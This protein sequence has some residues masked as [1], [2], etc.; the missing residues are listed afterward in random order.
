[1]N[2]PIPHR[3]S[4]P[5]GVLTVPARL[6]AT[7]APRGP[8]GWRLDGWV[9][10]FLFCFVSNAQIPG[11]QISP[12][13]WMVAASIGL[14][15]ASGKPVWFSLRAPENR[16][17][18]WYALALLGDWLLS[19]LYGTRQQMSGIVQLSMLIAATYAIQN[20]RTQWGLDRLVWFF[21][22][23]LGASMVVFLLGL[24]SED[25]MQRLAV[26]LPDSRSGVFVVARGLSRAPHIIGY[27]ITALWLFL[28]I[29]VL[30]GRNLVLRGAYGIGSAFCTM[31]L[32][33][34]GT[35]SGA[36][37]I[38]VALAI[39]CVMIPRMRRLTI[40][41]AV[42]L[43]GLYVFA[44]TMSLRFWH[45]ADDASWFKRRGALTERTYKVWDIGVRLDLQRYSL[46]LLMRYPL[47][48]AISHRDWTELAQQETD[49]FGHGEAIGV[50]NAFL[51]YALTNGIL[52]GLL[53]ISLAIYGL[54]VAVRCLR[55]VRLTPGTP[56][57]AT[58][59]PACYCA[60]VVNSMFHHASFLNEPVSAMI[61]F[62]LMAQYGLC[63]WRVPRW[64]PA[65][66]PSP[67]WG[68]ESGHLPV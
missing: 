63:L 51:S 31:A 60:D 50:H 55:F 35:R 18:G 26:I 68:N 19:V 56:L 21:F 36:L 20:G 5:P 3:V 23:I 17:L 1:M 14:L 39:L 37:G 34:Q 52:P 32:I 65:S 38:L 66:E 27:Q 44:N 16:Y 33:L 6:H 2:Q 22:S 42:L 13:T 30:V 48:L 41:L 24:Y 12:I 58:I 53:A 15:L 40:P 45:L 4:P 25:F 64:D 8:L 67:V 11:F 61:F 54:V 59:L 29:R 47:G 57:N 46:G 62:L 49:F 28:G 9:I 43:L 7:A 10:L